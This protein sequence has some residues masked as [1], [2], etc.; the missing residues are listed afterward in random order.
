[1]LMMFFGGFLSLVLILAGLMYLVGC[2][3]ERF[4]NWLVK[5]VFK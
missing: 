5:G 1:M 2:N 3:P 4:P